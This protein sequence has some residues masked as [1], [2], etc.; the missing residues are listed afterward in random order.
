MFDIVFV[1]GELVVGA[2]LLAGVL[3]IEADAGRFDFVE[4][5]LYFCNHVIF[6][7]SMLSYCGAG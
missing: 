1:H 6:H 5:S 4:R 3:S 7:R 2:D